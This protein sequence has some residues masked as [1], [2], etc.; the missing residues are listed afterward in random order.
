MALVCLLLIPNPT[1]VVSASA[2]MVSINI[3]NGT[4]FCN[5]INSGQYCRCIWLLICL[6]YGLGSDYDVDN[7][8][9]YWLF[10]GFY[11]THQ[12]SLLPK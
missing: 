11:C 4:E 3:G 7:Y 9:E 5:G 1:S 8:D 12:L 2:A 10:C 6:G